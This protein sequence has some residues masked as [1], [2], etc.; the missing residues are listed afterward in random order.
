LGGGFYFVDISSERARAYVKERTITQMKFFNPQVI[1]L[2]F[3]Y[4]IPGP[5]MG[6]PKN[7]AMRGERHA[8]EFIKLVSQA[9]KSINPDVTILYYGINP[10]YHEHIDIVSLDDQGDLWY[11]IKEGHD[12]WSIW[13][14]LLSNRKIAITGSSCYDWHKDDEVILNSLVLGSSNALLSTELSD[15]SPVPEKYL[16]RRLAANKWFRRTTLWEPAWINSHLGDLS[17]PQR[18]NCWGRVE[19]NKLTVIVLRGK[20]TPGYEAL[21]PYEWSGRWALISQDD[22]A[23]TESSKIAIIPF[24]AG[25][26][27]IQ[28]A[29]KPK[30]V[31]VLGLTG[32]S[33]A[34][35][36]TWNQG[37]L[38]IQ[39]DEI[40]L[41]NTAG[42]LVEF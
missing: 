15:G 35:N 31:S 17:E 6:V 12:Q 18:L 8:F 28:T 11:A 4:G 26:I 10:L 42:Y 39:I 36:W 34:R 13:A 20:K 9:A 27:T 32:E 1:K 3:G 22:R 37:G 5:Q 38:T 21:N 14:S 33:A 25:E 2:D 41:N 40:Q 7:P 19:D 30:N 24:D 16:N 23:I 29:S